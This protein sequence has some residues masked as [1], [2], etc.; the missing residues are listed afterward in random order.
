LASKGRRG[1]AGPQAA[2]RRHG[3]SDRNFWSLKIWTK[4]VTSRL[5]VPEPLA[6]L[7]NFTKSK[8][9]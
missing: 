1:L 6:N 8:N 5:V 3:P 2:T 4:R 7:S 9:A